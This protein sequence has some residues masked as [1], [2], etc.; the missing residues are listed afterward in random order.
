MRSFAKSVEASLPKN[1]SLPTE[2]A[3]LLEWIEKTKKVFRGPN[4]NCIGR[5]NL[6]N[7]CMYFEES[8]SDHFIVDGMPKHE[9]ARFAPILTTGG[10]GSVA[11]LWLDDD[12]EQRIVHV[13]SGSGSMLGGIWLD[14]PLD[15]LKLMAIGYEEL[16]WPEYYGDH[17]R[18]SAADPSQFRLPKEYRKWLTE[19]YGIEIPER[20]SDL[21]VST[22]DQSDEN[23]QDKFCLWFRRFHDPF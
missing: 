22:N 23:S 9:V 6:H 20:A 15:L 4:G 19:K 10:D 16:C 1:L 13:G 2:I 7:S 8:F 5:W 3:E 18:D 21:S 17:P 11:G 12:G 14:A